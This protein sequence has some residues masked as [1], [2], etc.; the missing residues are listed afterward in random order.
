MPTKKKTESDK[1]AEAM[2]KALAQADKEVR[3]AEKKKVNLPPITGTVVALKSFSSKRL[4][5]I[6]GR[7][8]KIGFNITEEEARSWL[9][10][11][12]VEMVNLHEGPSEVK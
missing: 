1:R 6:V 11:G 3:E 4:S 8:Y 5:Y 12:Y 10:C 9:K 2:R 7:K